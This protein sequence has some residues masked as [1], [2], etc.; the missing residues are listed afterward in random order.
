MK[1]R[2]LEHRR[3][4][5]KSLEMVKEARRSGHNNSYEMEKK[6]YAERLTLNVQTVGPGVVRGLCDADSPWPIL[7]VDTHRGSPIGWDIGVEQIHILL[8][9][10]EADV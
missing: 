5:R 1:G 2:A 10:I 7:G 4:Q 3:A 9:A 8:G 6:Q